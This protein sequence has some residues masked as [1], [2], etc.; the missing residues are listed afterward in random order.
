MW[1][2]C[3]TTSTTAACCSL[4]HHFGLIV[5]ISPQYSKVVTS[6]VAPSSPLNSTICRAN[7]SMISS[8]ADRLW[9]AVAPSISISG[10]RLASLLSLGFPSASTGNSNVELIASILPPRS[11]SCTLVLMSFWPS[12]YYTILPDLHGSPWPL[13][14][15]NE[16]DWP[17]AQLISGLWVMN[18]GNPSTSPYVLIG[19]TSTSGLW[20]GDKWSI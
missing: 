11:H 19:M 20:T 13:G 1:G 18:H 3:S 6:I 15:L 7:L 2:G 9:N 17:V 12:Y 4:V 10:V 5:S 14:V 8:L 16:V